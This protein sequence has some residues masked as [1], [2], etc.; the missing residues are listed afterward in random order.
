MFGVFGEGLQKGSATFKYKTN[1]VV[2]IIIIINIIV[3]MVICIA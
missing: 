2:I 1:Y 3:V